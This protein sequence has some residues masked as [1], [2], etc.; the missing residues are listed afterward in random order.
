MAE[1]LD[2]LKP[3]LDKTKVAV[4]ASSDNNAPW[5]TTVFFFYDEKLNIYFTSKTN[6]RHS[7]ENIKN[8]KVSVAI[9]NQTVTM[10]DK[11]TGLQIEGNC[12]PISGD[13][14]KN[15][16]TVFLKRFPVAAEKMPEE[17]FTRDESSFKEEEVVNRIWKVA[18]SLIKVFDKQSYEGGFK[19]FNL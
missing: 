16:Y 10:G 2:T 7:K 19:I 13:E 5:V 14:A 1:P 11:L 12:V 18:P 9:S 4:I 6:T 17:I 3:Y 15:A 8:S